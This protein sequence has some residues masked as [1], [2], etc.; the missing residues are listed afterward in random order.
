[1]RD[2]HLMLA[3]AEG[4]GESPVPALLAP[5]LDPRLVLREPPGPPDV[6]PR[7]ALNEVKTVPSKLVQFSRCP[8]ARLN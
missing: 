5:D 1:V 4:F 3:L 6:P 2:A 8:R 7:A